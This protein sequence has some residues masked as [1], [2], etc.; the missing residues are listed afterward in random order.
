M[1]DIDASA[2]TSNDLTAALRDV[3]DGRWAATRNVVRDLIDEKSLVPL[4]GV[5]LAEYRTLMLD[6]MA[7]MVP[8]GFPADGFRPEHGGS[9]DVGAAV[10]AIETLGYGDLSLMVKAGVQWGLFGGAVE[11]LGTDRHHEKYVRGLIDLDVVGCFAMTETGHGS[12]VQALETTATYDAATG[13]FVINSPSASARKDYIGGAAEHAGYAA[14]FAQLITAGPGEEP[15]GRG[16][17]CF[18]VPIRDADGADLPGVTTS[19]CGY[20]GGLP[21]V[22]NGRIMF[23]GVRIPREDLLNRYADVAADGTYSSPI[24]SDNRRFFTMLGTLIRG[25]VTVG[26]AAGAAGRLGLALAVKYALVRR[27][28]SAPGQDSELVLMDYRAHQRRLLPLV[29]RAYAFGLAQNEVVAELHELQTA[30]PSD[31]DPDAIRKLEVKAAAIKAGHTELA[32]RAISEAREACGGAGYLDENRLS[33]LRGDID[34]F[35]TFE[36]DN[37]ILR[38]L[39]AKQLLTAYADDVSDLDAVGWIRFV[40][41]TVKDIALEKTAARQVVQTLLDDSDEDPENSEL[42][43]PGT[44]LRLLRNREDHLLRTAA[45]RMRRAKDE[46]ADAQEVFTSTQDH[47]IKVGDAHIERIVLEIVVDV[48]GKITDTQTRTLLKRVRDLFVYS[49]LE[50]DLGWFLMHRHVSVERAKAIRR[51]VNE[52]CGTLRPHAAELVDAFGVP[53]VALDVPMIEHR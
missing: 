45:N 27:Q 28:F 50:D 25:R 9:G 20:K 46:D 12:N 36:G 15:T 4:S 41:S 21:G 24:E 3:L 51:G 2:P 19:D 33:R 11:N 35:T 22:D 39:V 34:V 32:S 53:A 7:A 52:L 42:S 16:V 8:L 48:I 13:E 44:Q 37:L 14:V 31:V 47:L 49:L 5:S 40:A 10:T 29:A 18:V 26:A 30:D 23:D 38:Q 6:Q 17:H 1:T 43:H